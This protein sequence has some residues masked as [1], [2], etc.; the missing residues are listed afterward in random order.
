MCV[1]GDG[2]KLANYYMRKVTGRLMLSTNLERFLELG[3]FTGC[4]TFQ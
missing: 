2:G 4:K 3:Y 1:C